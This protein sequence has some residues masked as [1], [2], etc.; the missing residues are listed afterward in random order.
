MAKLLFTS[1]VTLQTS[2]KGQSERDRITKGRLTRT[3]TR[4]AVVDDLSDE[5]A[6]S[7]IEGGYA[8]KHT[9]KAVEEAGLAPV[10]PAS[11]PAPDTVLA[12]DARGQ[13]VRYEDPREKGPLTGVPGTRDA[14]EEELPLNSRPS[15]GAIEV[16]DGTGNTA[17]PA[18]VPPTGTEVTETGKTVSEQS[19]SQADATGAAGGAPIV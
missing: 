11:A 15:A 7:A 2:P 5:D 12:R 10:A 1:N 3:F 17:T 13:L 19:K 6:K 4:G 16:I 14:V 9:A 18:A 8:V